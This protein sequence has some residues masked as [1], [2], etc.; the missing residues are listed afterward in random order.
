MLT[1]NDEDR[2]LFKARLQAGAVADGSGCVIWRGAPVQN[3]GYG[4][5][6]IGSRAKGRVRGDYVH[7]I[8]YLVFHGPIAAGLMVCHSCDVPMCVNPSHL[9]LGTAADNMRDKALKDRAPRFFGN[10]NPAARLSEGQVQKIREKLSSGELV[11]EIAREFGVCH[12]TISLIK[13]NKIWRL[14]EQ[15]ASTS[16]T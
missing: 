8:A 6:T 11:T 1:V 2:E 10:K 12:Q 9:F 5:L 14:A 13:A 16:A 3:S 7:R 15:E 4:R